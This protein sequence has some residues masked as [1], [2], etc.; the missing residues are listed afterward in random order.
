MSHARPTRPTH[1]TRPASPDAPPRLRSLL[2]APAVRPELLAKMPATGADGIVIDCEDATPPN[3]KAEGRA[4]AAR[5]APELAGPGCAVY[6]RVNAVP[7]EWFADDV[8]QGLCDA[9]AGVVV[10]KLES[11]DQAGRVA[12]A[13]DA[14]GHAALPILAGLETALGVADARAVL[15]HPRIHA[16]YFGA[17][18][19]IADMG[20]VR[21]AQ[22]QE[23]LYARSQVAL[24]GRLAGVPVLDQVVTDF[25]NDLAF[26]AEVRDARA[27]GYAGKLCIHPKQVALANAGFVPSD[28]EVEQARRLLAAYEEASARGVAAISF[29]GQMVDE[30]LA[31]RARQTLA[32]RGE[33]SR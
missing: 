10:P 7:S 4:N 1:Q 23:V 2:F 16:A 13:L 20:G 27:L 6:V 26:E 30:P 8:A 28:E 17:E 21:T 32:A 15:G 24:A 9:L 25:R 19:F 31:A 12:D 22:N 3:A 33:E 14:A 18:D 29:E 5:L 11:L